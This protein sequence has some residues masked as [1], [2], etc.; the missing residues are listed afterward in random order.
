MASLAAAA[1]VLVVGTDA[2]SVAVAV[3]AAHAQ[4]C[5]PRGILA[6]LALE[7]MRKL[8]KPPET[9]T[10]L[11]GGG[12]SHSTFHVTRSPWE[13]CGLR[14]R[15]SQGCAHPGPGVANF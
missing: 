10:R 13:L 15:M 7:S 5:A 6:R 11:A 4:T 3:E 12:A 14:G 1:S 2:F 8:R 9:Y